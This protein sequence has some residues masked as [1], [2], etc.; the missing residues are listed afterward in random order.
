MVISIVI[1]AHNEEGNIRATLNDVIKT[2]SHPHEV[3]VVDDHSEDS[4]ARIV[5]EFM[6]KNDFVR[7]IHNHR[8]KGFS[9][10]LI[11]GLENASGE[12]VVPVMAD[13]CD[14]LS[15][16]EAMFNKLQEGYDVVCGS[17]YMPEGR[18]IGGPLLQSF[19]SRF[20]GLTL[21]WITGIPTYDAPNA[22]K[23]YRKK[24]LDSLKIEEA[25]FA[26]SMQITLKAFFKGCRITEVP[27]TWKSRIVGKSG[28]KNF[29]Q[30]KDYFYWYFWAIK[31]Y[32][33]SYSTK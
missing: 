14:D 15:T 27:T 22:F 23:M 32:L 29:R 9:N 8:P 12:V 10:A 25:G 30:A 11:T 3:V 13:L 26:V 18:K 31:E 1:P 2:V 28:F 7:L 5:R 21:H 33:T 20:V 24:L 17:R 16:I 19:F 6:E 4:T